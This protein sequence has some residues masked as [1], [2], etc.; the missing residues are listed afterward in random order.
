[1]GA[2]RQPMERLYSLQLSA[3]YCVCDLVA[4]VAGLVGASTTS[5]GAHVDVGESEAVRSAV[6]DGQLGRQGRHGRKI[7]SPTPRGSCSRTSCPL[8]QH[9]DSAVRGRNGD[10]SMGPDRPRPLGD[11]LRFGAFDR[12]QGLV[13]GPH[14]LDISRRERI[15]LGMANSSGLSGSRNE[16]SLRPATY[17]FM[18]DA[19]KV[20]NA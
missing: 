13:R 17:Q 9:T 20:G 7:V 10:P 3:A 14:G 16:G 6:E 15:R 11:D 1:M 5:L 18:H 12:T 8:G 4:S 2:P 19:A